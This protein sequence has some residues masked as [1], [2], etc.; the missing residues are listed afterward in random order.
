MAGRCWHRRK[1]LGDYV[2]EG[3]TCVQD[4]TIFTEGDLIELASRAGMKL[5]ERR[6]LMN[7]VTEISRET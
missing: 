7:A 3:V 1:I 2:G 6:H 5:L 4:M